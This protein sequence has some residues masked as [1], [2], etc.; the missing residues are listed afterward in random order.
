M[1]NQIMTKIKEESG[2]IQSQVGG[3]FDITLDA[4]LNRRN[5]MFESFV[6]I[7]PHMEQT[8]SLTLYLILDVLTIRIFVASGDLKNS[9]PK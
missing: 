4:A 6:E 1:L 2:V 8:N 3:M 7:N 5:K 9:T